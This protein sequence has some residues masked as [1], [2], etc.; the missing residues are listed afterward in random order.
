[1]GNKSIL[2]FYKNAPYNIRSTMGMRKVSYIRCS[3]LKIYHCRCKYNMHGMFNSKTNSHKNP[4]CT[5]CYK[6]TLLG[7]LM[8]VSSHRK[9][10][11]IEL[12]SC[13]I[14]ASY[15][16]FTLLSKEENVDPCQCLCPPV[17][18]APSEAAGM[19]DSCSSLSL[20]WAKSEEPK[21][22]RRHSAGLLSKP[23]RS[24]R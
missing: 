14:F 13:S 23:A 9:K 10:N 11:W 21:E 6:A 4:P 17:D 22:S 8:Q 16:G 2:S 24:A 19:T 3:H 1:M 5:N 7:D 15:W 18:R 12:V 20:S